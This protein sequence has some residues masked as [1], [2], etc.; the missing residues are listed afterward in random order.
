MRASL[1]RHWA[2]MMIVI[3]CGLGLLNMTGPVR[4]QNLGSWIDPYRPALLPDFA[5][6][7]LTY[8]DAPRYTLDLVL[9]VTPT[10]AAINGHQSVLY[11][12]RAAIPLPDIV[13]RLYPNLDS[14]GGE[15]TVSSL[16]MG[17][18]PLDS[19]LDTTRTVLT[20]ALPEPLAPGDAI[21]LDMDFTIT[22]QAEKVAL[23]AQFSYLKGVL[24]L[25]NAYPVLS[26]FTPGQGWWQI[27]EQPQGDAVFSETGFYEVTITAPENLILAASGSEVNLTAN[28][29]GTLTHQYVAPL[30]RDFAW[31]ASENYVSLSGEQDGVA[32]NLY[33][34]DTLPGAEETARA[35]LKMTQDSVRVYNQVFGR[36]P[37]RELDVVATPTGAGGIEY[38]GVFVVAFDV[39]NK[40]DNFFEFVI[41]HEAAHQWW[42]SLVGNDQTLDPWIDEALAQYS[43]ALYIRDLEG[44][45]AYVAA[46][47]SFRAQYE[48]FADAVLGQVDPADLVI[49]R[50]VTAYPG[51][52]YFY[53]V[54]QR[55]PVFYATLADTYGV[56]RVTAMLGV[57]F[58]TFRYQEIGSDDLLS[59]YESA[60]GEDLD[61]LIAEWV[62]SVPV[63]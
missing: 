31:F 62:G 14:Y 1:I 6:D 19:S 27:T 50:P 25:P 56:D 29:D 60:L 32:I 63:G 59:C 51:P 58:E 18:T 44:P 20:V 24:A 28:G 17:N 5:A 33:Y 13:F 23:Y 42:Y 21:T 46:L 41:A 54:Y 49:G 16:M 61:L 52:A 11:T 55:G 10:E 38:P 12:N 34:V 30:M 22:I 57:C 45:A 43:V 2:G 35:G 15:M 53:V 48:M 37:F 4:A 36:Y 3:V 7:M 40:E 39:W 8:A 26:V 47:E 9:T